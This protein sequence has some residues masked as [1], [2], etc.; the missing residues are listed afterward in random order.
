MK[1]L[2]QLLD[3]FAGA[4]KP[5]AVSTVV[6]AAP[7][8]PKTSCPPR[9]VEGR[10]EFHGLLWFPVLTV[11]DDEKLVIAAKAGLPH[12]VRCERPMILRTGAREEWACAGC[13][14]KRPGSE[15][16]FFA[17]D[18]VIVEGMKEF[19]DGHPDFRAAP[20]LPTATRVGLI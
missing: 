14:Q 3:R 13:G 8:P 10:R 19:F 1:P 17:A 15:A 4:F 6:T 5:A 18:S 11:Q 9:M 20:G 2:T 16:D 7:E 12:C